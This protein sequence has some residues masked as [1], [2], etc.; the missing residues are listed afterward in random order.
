M[1]LPLK[2]IGGCALVLVPG[3]ATVLTVGPPVWDWSYIRAFVV[4][5][6]PLSLAWA[7][8]FYYND[9]YELRLRD[10]ISRF[11]PR[12]LRSCL[13]AFALF[14][15]LSLILQAVSPLVSPT[16]KTFHFTLVMMLLLLLPVRQAT[17]AMVRRGIVGERAVVFGN[18]PLGFQLVEELTKRPDLYHTVVTVAAEP[19]SS[20][21]GCGSGE[22]LE[23]EIKERRPDCIFLALADRRNVL[24]VEYLIQARLRGIRVEDA[25]DVYERLTKKLAVEHL[26]PSSFLFSRQLPTSTRYLDIPRVLSVMMVALGLVVS[27]PLMALI[28][29]AVKIDSP[30]PVLFRQERVGW[31][32]QVFLL[33]KFRTMRNVNPAAPHT[34]WQRDDVGRVTR[35]GR[36]LRRTRLDELPQLWNILRGDM[37]FIGPRP[38]MV[39]N[40]E[41]MAR[42]IPFYRLRHIIRPGI[43]GW[44]Q[45]KNGYAVNRANVHEKVRYD[46]YYLK[47]RCF[48]L[49]LVILLESVRVVLFG[50][51]VRDV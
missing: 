42:E 32:D 29:L 9:L 24:P 47:N 37:N 46:L 18:G 28:A 8:A 31:R 45:V 36:W 7:A 14:L 10:S 50:R 21:E 51:G 40:V 33:Y 15:V 3:A 35:I 27:A 26:K 34:T 12:M 20:E 41:E 17:H 19:V 5:A 49:N 11:V 4:E 6:V 25:V 39:E 44:A 38:E 13:L 30:G 43:T 23:R 22:R 48:T 2:R 16:L 1:T